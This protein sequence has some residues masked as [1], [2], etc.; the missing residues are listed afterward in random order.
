[1]HC[2]LLICIRFASFC[3]FL[4]TV[5][6]ALFPM[7]QSLLGI[8]NHKETRLGE[9][10]LLSY[11]SQLAF[12]MA[13]LASDLEE[14]EDKKNQCQHIFLYKFIFM[15]NPAHVQFCKCT[16]LFFHVNYT[17]VASFYN[18]YPS[19]QQIY[20]N[21][22]RYLLKTLSLCTTDSDF[23]EDESIP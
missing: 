3:P 17:I 15:C 23:P 14:W 22:D 21:I 5:L 2:L 4:S 10:F 16:M 9:A 1:M 7:C 20:V 18:I 19:L 12:S 6:H 8:T 11:F 13:Y